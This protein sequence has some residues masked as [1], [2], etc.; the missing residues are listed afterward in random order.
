V[1]AHDITSVV[2]VNY[3]GR[4]YLFDC[5]T[6]LERQT[7]PRHRYEILLIDNGSHDGSVE[8]VRA[9]FP[10]VR[11]IALDDNLG[12][13]GANNLG[14]RLSRGRYVVLL[15]NDTRV[16]P[17]WLKAL[18]DAADASGRIGGVSSRLLFRDEPGRVNSTGLVL[19]RDGRGGDRHLRQPDGPAAR[20]PAE[21]FGGC[22][23]SLL[24]TRELLD[25]LGGFDPALFMYY[26]DL[27]LAWRARLRGWRFVYAPDSIVEHVCGGSTAPAS[28]F[29]LRQ[30]ERNRTLVSLRN[31]PPFLAAWAVVGLLLRC[32]RLGYRYLL[33]RRQY[34]LSRGHLRAMAS[35]AASVVGR[36]PV[37]LLERYRTRVERRRCPDR[38]ILRFVR[39]HP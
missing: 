23:A 26:E 12:F 16:H 9:H 29:L 19:Y 24:L 7:L 14:F 5:L 10:G 8:F 37:T 20:V 11:V 31:A 36:L 35:A 1:V 15:N 17:N 32:G 38:A 25:D 6:A 3:N 13:T 2:I 18:A 4:R 28:P 30:I 21:V 33:L 27:D 34:A 22:G 39:P